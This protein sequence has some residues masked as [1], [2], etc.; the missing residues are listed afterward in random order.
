[1]RVAIVGGIYGKSAA[2]R[3]GHR[4]APETTLE[5]GMRRRGIDVATFS[6]FTPIDCGGFDVVHVHHL[7]W[8]AIRVATDRSRA[9]FVFT[10]HNPQYMSEALPAHWG[11][12]MQFVLRRADLTI[13]LSDRERAFQ[14]WKYKVEAATSVVIANGIPTELFSKRERNRRAPG[15]PWRILY[16]GQLNQIKRVDVL[17]QAFARI[18]FPATLTLAY[19]N[20]ELESSLRSLAADL[21]IAD[22][23]NFA[24]QKSPE[25]L[26]WL[27]NGSDLFVLPSSGEALPSVITEAMLCG[28]PIVSTDVGGIREQL[29]GFGTLVPP[30]DP[31]ALGAA[32]AD[33]LTHY[34]RFEC[35]GGE[36]SAYAQRAFSVDAMVD[37]HIDLY[38]RLAV[39]AIRRRSRRSLGAASSLAR[40]GLG[41]WP[42]ARSLAAGQRDAAAAGGA[43]RARSEGY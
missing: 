14:E 42:K 9:A 40:L 15:T 4:I 11:L 12:A 8:G 37:R 1:M 5:D 21:G 18:P 41:L 20:G 2:Y 10:P 35:H 39:P 32:I 25:E 28:T 17:L 6:H 19:Q 34:D 38:R 16:V 43:E 30:N 23:I 7:S 26:C 22:R 36:M 27:Y 29:G 33:V 31:Q 3:Q 13:A 24:G